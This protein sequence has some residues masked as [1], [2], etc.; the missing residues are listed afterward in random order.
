MPRQYSPE[1]RDRALRMLDTMMEA[2]DISEFEAIKSVASKLGISEESVRRWRRKAQVDAGERSGTTS[3]EHTE[4]RKLKREVAELRR[5][6]ELL[7]SASAFFAAELD[8]PV[9]K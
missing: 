6:N 8:R 4:I 5:A 7:K 3:A 9:T 1:F 2:S